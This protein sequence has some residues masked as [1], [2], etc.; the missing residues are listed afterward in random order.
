MVLAGA[1]RVCGV[2]T[3]AGQGRAGW[4]G[5]G[6]GEA[7]APVSPACHLHK[8]SLC[9]AR[10]ARKVEGGR[11]GCSA[12]SGLLFFEQSRLYLNLADTLGF[13]PLDVPSHSTILPFIVY[14]FHLYFYLHLV[15][16]MFIQA[17]V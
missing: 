8:V 6:R 15:N 7:V 17:G 9:G 1:G 5:A 4:G 16:C 10:R 3:C 13:P 14:V 2:N 12:S 11:C